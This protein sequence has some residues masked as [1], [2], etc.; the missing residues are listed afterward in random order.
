MRARRRRERS[1][2]GPEVNVSETKDRTLKDEEIQTVWPRTDASSS[3]EAR[4]GDPDTQDADTDTS[5]TAV[6]DTDSTDATQTGDMVDE[7]D[8]TQGGDLVDVKDTV[9]EDQIDGVDS[10]GADVDATDS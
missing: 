9:D 5:D 3:T 6:G 10:E 1:T 7:E 4:T 2:D 8:Q